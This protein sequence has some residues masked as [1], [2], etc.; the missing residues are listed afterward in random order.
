[1]VNILGA[2]IKYFDKGRLRKKD[3]TLVPGEEF[4]R[5]WRGGKAAGGR[6][7]GQVTHMTSMVRSGEMVQGWLKLL[8]V[9]S[10]L[11]QTAQALRGNEAT[12]RGPAFSPPLKHS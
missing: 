6:S 2:V 12:H 5:L 3:F 9:L 7:S 10:S 4:C 1:M 8:S 11:T